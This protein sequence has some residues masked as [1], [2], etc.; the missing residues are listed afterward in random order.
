MPRVIDQA[1]VL[2][3]TD[4]SETSQLVTLLTREQGK[5][6]GLAKGSK[7]LSPSSVA[8]F[9]GGFELLTLGQVVA[10]VRPTSDLA[11]LT[12]WDL[13]QTHRHLRD[14]LP[15]QHRALYAVDLCQAMLADH[16]PHPGAFAIL[17]ALLREFADPSALE[18]GLLR[19]QWALLADTGYRPQLDQDVRA[20]QPL[21][22]AASYTFDAR[23]GGLTASDTLD[24]NTSW[25]VR[26]ETVTLLRAVRDDLR[27][28]AEEVAVRRANQLLCVYFRF[29][30]DRA[31]P[32]M[33]LVLEV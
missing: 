3:C 11:T 19:F 27:I 24:S 22:E 31:L 5:L 23:A 33:E 21:T 15:A 6:R 13:Q 8:R 1:I 30:L 7:R 12:E 26:H 10:T 9:S 20:G 2:R 4:W 17:G 29:I 28:A 14:Q 32:T 25:R 16:D 18:P